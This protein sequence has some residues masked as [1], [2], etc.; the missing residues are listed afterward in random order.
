M[1]TS[2]ILDPLISRPVQEILTAVLLERDEPWYFR[3]LA[4]RLGRTPSTLQRPLESLVRAG[5]LRKWSDG[6]RVYFACHPD[7]PVLGELRVMLEKTVGL[8]DV[9]R[10]VLQRQ[11]KAIRV[12]FVFGSVARGAERSDSDVDLLIVGSTNLAALSPALA[13]AEARLRRR[14]NATIYLPSEFTEKLANKNHFLR[15]VLAEEKIFVIGSAHDLEKLARSR[16]RRTA[17]HE[18]G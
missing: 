18:Q 10:E 9:L 11:A 15:S 6:N 2:N 17:R 8:V 3:D 13:K 1:R 16:P 14:V 5:I 12:A 7:C 4:Q